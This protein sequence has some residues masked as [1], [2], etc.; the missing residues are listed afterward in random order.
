MGI[1]G[2]WSMLKGEE[3]DYRALK[4]KR[5]CVDG[6]IVLFACIHSTDVRFITE[7]TLTRVGKLLSL[8]IDP[9]LVFDGKKPFFKRRLGAR[10]TQ[11]QTSYTPT[12][13]EPE[14]PSIYAE[15]ETTRFSSLQIDKIVSRHN[16]LKKI[17]EKRIHGN[18]SL[19][20]TLTHLKPPTKTQTIPEPSN[21]YQETDDLIYQL[22]E[23]IF[24][25]IDK[26]NPQ[27]TLHPDTPAAPTAAPKPEKLEKPETSDNLEKTEKTHTP[28]EPSE[29]Q[30]QMETYTLPKEDMYLNKESVP[31]EELEFSYKV[32]T[33]ALDILN[34]KYALAPA[35]S[36]AVYKSIESALGTN[37]V[38]TDDS[39]IFL[40]STQPIYRHFFTKTHAPKVYA[41]SSTPLPYSWLELTILAWLLGSDYSPGI[42]GVGPSKAS[43]FI[44]RYREHSSSLLLDLHALSSAIAAL[45]PQIQPNDISVLKRVI[46]IYS[47]T[48]F[49][50]K[51]ENL[52]FKAIDKPK[53]SVFIKKRTNWRNTDLVLFM[54]MIEKT[55]C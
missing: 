46:R 31:K 52:P 14:A 40:F 50:V 47:E 29:Y 36:D 22:K 25:E 5:L 34:V 11:T 43:A 4:E 15:M 6:N 38:V 26:T 49:K 32:I 48:E 24:E 10:P 19:A 39:D 2:L 28:N 3:V 54:E 27:N 1:R 13:P 18:S 16:Y 37:G 45:A 53:L 41:S 51:I 20:Y 17:K 9:I 23:L 7:Y 35:E 42:K 30:R 8:G 55:N 12:Q 44:Q 33:D 21:P